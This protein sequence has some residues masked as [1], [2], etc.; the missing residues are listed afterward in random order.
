MGGRNRSA[1]GR[2]ARGKRSRSYGR[3]EKSDSHESLQSKQKG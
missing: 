2:A 3:N 1:A